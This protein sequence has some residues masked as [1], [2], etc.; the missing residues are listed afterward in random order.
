MISLRYHIVSLVAVFLALA[1]GIVVG[2][3]V[4]QE[5]T[6]SALRATSQEVRQRSEENRTENLALKQEISR[7]QAFG[8]TVLP[9][10][11]QDRLKGR[12]VVLVDTDKVDSGLRDG[13]RKVLEDAGARVDGQITFADE[14]LV[15]GADADR[16]AMARLLAV[17][18]GGAPE[19]LR[20]ELVKKLAARLATSTA[21]PQEDSRRASDMLT[22][23][24]DADFLAD[25]KLR[26]PLAAGTD[27]FPRQGSMFVLLG[28]AATATAAVAPDA[29][30]V[31]LAEQVSTQAG[32]P[33]AGGEAAA[34]PK[35]SSWILALR[36]N[37]AVSRRVSGIDSVDTVYGQL[38]LV[39]ALEDSLQQLPAGQYGFKDGASGLLPERTE[40]S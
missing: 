28:P 23:L 14:R 33:V 37:R 31:P 5:G 32:V 26:R 7:H 15:L 36:D 16:T 29:F 25:L 18:D 20:G 2:S 10:L 4:L 11:V 34:V 30:L 22:G 3:T 17:E 35:D 39:E 24:E 13:V 40:G 6:V 38:A 27:P 21:L 12:S 1:L 9:E 8:T 19:V